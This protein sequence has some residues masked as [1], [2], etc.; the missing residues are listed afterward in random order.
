MNYTPFHIAGNTFCNIKRIKSYA[1]ILSIL[2]IKLLHY[3]VTVIKQ[4][5]IEEEIN[6]HTNGTEESPEIDLHTYG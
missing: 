3:N 4:C 5:G 1:C 2:L 6:T